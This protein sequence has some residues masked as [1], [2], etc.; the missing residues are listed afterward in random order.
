MLSEIVDWVEQKPHSWQIAID[1]LIRKNNLS[2]VDLDEIKNV[3]KTENGLQNTSY[4]SVN[5]VALRA[6]I[7]GSS[8][9]SN[10]SLTKIHGIQ[11]INALSGTASLEF[12]NSGLTVVYGDNGS[13]KSSYTSI[14]KHVCN[15]R[16]HKPLISHNLYNATSFSVSKQAQVDYS[17]NGGPSRT[18]SLSNG[19]VSDGVLKKIDVFD[20]FSAQHYIDGEDEIA[21]I[22]KGLALIEKFALCL[23]TIDT[24]LEAEKALLDAAKFDFTLLQLDDDSN[25]KRF[26]NGLNLST[27]RAQLWAACYWDAAKDNRI[28]EIATLIAALKATDPL[29]TIA[30]NQVK[31][32]RLKLFRDK[33]NSLETNLVSSE[34]TAHIDTILN[35]YAAAADALRISSESAFSGLPLNNVGGDTWKQLWESARRFYNE[36]RNAEIFPETNM[37]SNCPLCLQTL[38]AEAKSKFQSFEEFIKHDTQKIFNSAAKI[39]GE[40]IQ[41]LVNLDFDFA[42][43]EPTI[44]ELEVYE[45]DFRSKN[46]TYIA[47]LKAAREVHLANMREK[48]T[49]ANP[50]TELTE[51]SK[52]YIDSIIANLESES[53][54][55]QTLSI[56]DELEPLEK[57]IKEL[58]NAKQLHAYYSR[59]GKELFRLKK[60]KLLATCKSQCNT[61]ASTT[62]SNELASIYV[63]QNLQIKFQEELTKLGFKNIK[64]EADTRG[65]RGKQYHYLKL[66]EPHAG[67][68]PLKEILSEGEHRCIALATFLSELTLSDH[69]SAI[70]FDDPVCSLDHKWRNKIA[71]RIVEESKIRQVI[72]FTHDIS[73]LLMLQ[74]HCDRAGLNKE[75]KSLTRK[76]QETGIVASN[77][78]WD[79]LPVKTRISIL[80]TDHV[81][82]DQIE[83]NST[84]EEYKAA[85]LPLY[86]KLRETWE[87]AIEEVVLHEVIKR[88]GREIQTKRLAKVIDLTQDDYDLIDLNM[89]K[90]STY[91]LGHDS[92]GALNEQIPDAAEFLADAK[93]LEEFVKTIR[94]RRN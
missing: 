42:V 25:A 57:E 37:D 45:S 16:G 48:V 13:G 56:A 20:S 68:I 62:L 44:V 29:K 93:I 85:I 34:A 84:E 18:I 63:T 35:D 51:N 40:K 69:L 58:N 12:L 1:R 54:R 27:T 2:R 83:K 94:T 31:I 41:T 49:T 81:K 39:Y 52:E 7:S 15:T 3:C 53:I 73:F 19:V 76:I 71:H 14:L 86:G 72:V 70:I 4:T 17:E 64:V 74:E 60:S 6:Y 91:F 79:A 28:S 82:V 21:F 50:L 32:N 88:F 26:L 78:P 5:F 46:E 59:I 67:N 80:K 30:N 10:I 9:N 8:S 38:S 92:A 87:R 77:P 75:I 66:N 23:K 22:P 43:F 33:F 89:S 90:C 61:R 55:L 24:E 11:N 65:E 36:S 47:E